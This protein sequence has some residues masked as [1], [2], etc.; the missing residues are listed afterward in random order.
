M[1]TAGEWDRLKKEGHEQAE[2]NLF[3]SSEAKYFFWQKFNGSF[4]HRHPS[5]SK[6]GSL[7][8]IALIRINGTFNFTKYVQPAC[9]PTRVGNSPS[10]LFALRTSRAFSLQ[11]Q[12]A[13]F[14]QKNTCLVSGWGTFEPG[15]KYNGSSSQARGDNFDTDKK[16]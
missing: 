10:H 11:Y 4:I 5:F 7:N 1:V 9:F 3:N 13:S 6:K 2:I 8:D 14:S 15:A 16:H 12:N